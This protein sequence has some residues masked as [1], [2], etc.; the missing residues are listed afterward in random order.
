MNPPGGGHD[1][2]LSIFSSTP[3]GAVAAA[4][5]F[6]GATQVGSFDDGARP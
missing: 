4:D 1:G 2:D 3:S 5:P 6:L